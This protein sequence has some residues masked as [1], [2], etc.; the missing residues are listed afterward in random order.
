M[1]L[2]LLLP[3]SI[4]FLPFFPLYF[5]FHPSALLRLGFPRLCVSIACIL[6]LYF[7][8]RL[9][10]FFCI[11][12]IAFSLFLYFLHH[13]TYH[14]CFLLLPTFPLSSFL[15]MYRSPLKRRGMCSTLLQI[16]NDYGKKICQIKDKYGKQ[17]ELNVVNPKPYI[18][19]YFCHSSSH[20]QAFPL[21]YPAFLMAGGMR[22]H[23]QYS[24]P[25]FQ[26]FT[27]HPS[28]FTPTLHSIIP[29]SSPILLPL[30]PSFLSNAPSAVQESPPLLSYLIIA[31]LTSY[32]MYPFRLR[33]CAGNKLKFTFPSRMLCLLY[34]VAA[35]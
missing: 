6:F 11:S 7:F 31:A 29:P 35:D 23:A 28:P 16:D 2:S 15:C 26:P 1:T 21:P 33:V 13:L 34:L 4:P 5:F 30:Q 14:R 22:S 12:F 9:S 20:A 18:L 19:M 17:N 10:L 8:H 25:S 24:H 27:L 32:H 3:A